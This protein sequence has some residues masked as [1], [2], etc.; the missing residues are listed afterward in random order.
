MKMKSPH[1]TIF[2]NV[3]IHAL[4]TLYVP[5]PSYRKNFKKTV[6]FRKSSIRRPSIQPKK[7]LPNALSLRSA[8]PRVRPVQLMN[9]CCRSPFSPTI[10]SSHPK[11]L[12]SS[13]KR[14][15]KVS[16]VAILFIVDDERFVTH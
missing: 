6:Q 11:Q 16:C 7:H 9:S 10:L 14:T 15:F 13:Q 3:L 4:M 5:P 8:T 12:S 2:S 1:A